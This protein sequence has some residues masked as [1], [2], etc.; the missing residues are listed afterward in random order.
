MHMAPL[1]VG[2]V[3][4]KGGQ[5]IRDLMEESGARIWIDQDSM[6]PQDPRIVY[7][8]G[9]RSSVEAA[10]HMITD[11]IA[12]APTEA[13]NSKQSSIPG[14]PSVGCPHDNCE[15]A[16]VS[17]TDS[18]NHL[19]A[20][21]T[22]NIGASEG[23]A[24]QLKLRE[25]KKN[26]EGKTW[27]EMTC[28]P[29]FVPLLI[30]RRGWT[31]KNI[32]DSSGARVDIDQNVT[33][34][35]ITISGSDAAVEIA[36]RMVGD[37]LSYPHSLLHGA[38]DD[39]DMFPT[40]EHMLGV[41][42]DVAAIL[43]R[44]SVG[45]DQS[46][47]ER[48]S[49]PANM[50]KSRSHS[51]PSSLIMTGDG[52]STISATSSLSSTPEPSVSNSKQSLVTAAPLSTPALEPEH[53][54]SLL[55]SLDCFA[56]VIP[57]HHSN[58]N[59]EPQ[60]ELE[61]LRVDHVPQNAHSL[62]PT[63]YVHNNSHGIAPVGQLGSG[64]PPTH[65][66]LSHGPTIFEHQPPPVSFTTGPP[67]TIQ[68]SPIPI[69][70]QHGFST[71]FSCLAK[72]ESHHSLRHSSIPAI[73]QE[74][75]QAVWGS[76]VQVDEGFGLAAAVDFLQYRREGDNLVPPVASQQRRISE[77]IGFPA[78]PGPA[79]LHGLGIDRQTSAPPLLASHVGVKDESNIVDSLFGASSDPRNDAALVSGVRGLS[80]DQPLGSTSVDPWGSGEVACFALPPLGTS[81]TLNSSLRQLQNGVAVPSLFSTTTAPDDRQHSR[82][83]WGAS[84]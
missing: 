54:H 46:N 18:T 58:L 11:V 59:C 6:R 48:A 32:Q 69:H 4:G 60:E 78:S 3:I 37:V 25:K 36:S 21:L 7:V 49:S 67:S 19:V 26:S 29:R 74:Q 34:R 15:V 61:G 24:F 72:P 28:D 9:Q 56:Q 77:I 42:E 62:H 12:K 1:I 13:P 79:G 22:V 31:I 8:S 14:A 45:W 2:W 53:P 75:P 52:K 20:G 68:P 50:P 81:T 33:P 71:A 70:P 40:G 27:R 23:S 63:K 57:Q 38:T 30:G 83:S 76:E 35:K 16:L 51:P 55:S 5:R 39:V 84:D 44:H 43:R 10:V 80:L 41:Q 73:H 82:F 47:L 66:P 17:P 65:P 64:L